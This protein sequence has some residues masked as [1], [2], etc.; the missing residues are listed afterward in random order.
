M[1]DSEIFWLTVEAKLKQK[2]ELGQNRG[3]SSWGIFEA[4]ILYKLHAALEAIFLIGKRRGYNAL[5]CTMATL[6]WLSKTTEDYIQISRSQ[7]IAFDV[8][9][10]SQTLLIFGMELWSD[11]CPHTW[12]GSLLFVACNVDNMIWIRPYIKSLNRA[13]KANLASDQTHQ[14]SITDVIKYTEK[15]WNTETPEWWSLNIYHKMLT[16]TLMTLVV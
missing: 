7:D 11:G 5:R 3:I 9:I 12:I 13:V 10:W 15:R 16:V 4:N 1:G 14:I 2:A 6:T 8:T